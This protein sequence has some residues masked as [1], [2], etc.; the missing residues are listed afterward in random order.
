MTLK[1]IH[2]QLLASKPESANHDAAGCK[3][4]IEALAAPSSEPVPTGGPKVSDPK[5]YTEDEMTALIT[6]KVADAT[7]DLQAKLEAFESQVSESEVQAK[8]DE[9][10]AEGEAKAAELQT[11]LDTAAIALKT[12]EDELTALKTY[13]D[14]EKA[15]ADE[16]AQIAAVSEERKNAVAEVASFR[17]DYVTEERI[18]RW[19]KMGEEE[20]AALLED[21]KAAS[22]KK[23]PAPAPKKIPATTAMVAAREGKVSH[24]AEVLSWRE[25]GVDARD[26]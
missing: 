18:A 9:A 10:K 12:A 22:A 25:A 16:A 2:D 14:E 4:C 23:P 15:K 11:E 24:V 20:F 26:I 6:S 13:L 19:A 8:I 7:K 3:F 17:D 5:T 21:Y 1:E